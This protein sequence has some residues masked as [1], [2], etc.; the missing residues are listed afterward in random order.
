MNL[1]YI[2]GNLFDHKEDLTT[3][4]WIVHANNCFGVWGS[5]F[6][7]ELATRYPDTY[8]IYQKSCITRRPCTGDVTVQKI[9]GADYKKML[10]NLFTSN[11]YGNQID[12]PEKI[13]ESTDEALRKFRHLLPIDDKHTIVSPKFNSGLFNVPWGQTEALI[14]KHFADIDIDWVVYYI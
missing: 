1:Q 13:I 11:G 14:H 7:K 4:L 9:D 12:S 8:K 10:I 3:N 6:A 2:K 5:G